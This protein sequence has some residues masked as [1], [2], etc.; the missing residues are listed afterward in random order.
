MTMTKKAMITKKRKNNQNSKR[1]NH[2]KTPTKSKILWW[3]TST[4]STSTSVGYWRNLKKKTSKPRTSSS[5]FTVSKSRFLSAGSSCRC[6]NDRRAP[7]GFR[8]ALILWTYSNH[9]HSPRH[10]TKTYPFRTSK[11]NSRC[12]RIMS[13][14]NKC[15]LMI[16]EDRS[17]PRQITSKKAK[18]M[19]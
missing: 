4:P 11:F 19:H 3:I 13:T 15:P 18:I 1:K 16:H 6:L 9:P 5:Q 2:L 8:T 7:T 10:I 14:L 12:T 17:W